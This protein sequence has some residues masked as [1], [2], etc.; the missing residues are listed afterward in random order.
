MSVQQLTVNQS[1]LEQAFG[2]KK[3]AEN[4]YEGLVPL[5]K[6]SLNSRGVY[7]GNLCGQALLV[8]ME[9]VPEG[10]SPHSLHSYFV[11]AG[12]DTIPCQFNVEQVLNG[13]NFANRLIKV[14]QRGDTKYIVMI[15]LTAKNSLK[16]ANKKYLSN[17]MGGDGTASLPMDFQVPPPA[18]FTRHL[19]SELETRTD[20]DHTSTLQHKFPPNFHNPALTQREEVKKAA[21]ERDLSFW[22]RVDDK[23]LHL[24]NNTNNKMK[25]AGFGVVSDSLYL[26][27]LSR[28]L[29]L[30]LKEK[31]TSGGKGEHFFSISLD[32]SIYFH[33]T[34][35]D[36]TKWMYFN[37]RAPRFANNRVLLQGSYYNEDGKLFA[38]IVQEGLVFFHSGSE[39]KAK[40]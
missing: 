37:F 2:I 33:D 26:T 38:S 7:G 19:H 4:L 12:D 21:A 9:T 35:F 3:L 15:S 36:P 18:P 11:K 39:L 40:L 23:L 1:K 29:H 16:E 6:P 20:F 30:P 27:S 17:Q 25:F 10:F 8:A 5:N 28:I 24:S 13:K 34:E 14:T 31:L 22:I 32:H